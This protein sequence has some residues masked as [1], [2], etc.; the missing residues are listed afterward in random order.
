MATVLINDF[1]LCQEHILEVCDDCNFDLREEN[2]AFYG[3]DSIDRDA[4]EV[5]PVT[6]ADDGS[7][8]CDKH[9]SQC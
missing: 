7:Y 1:V 9:Q 6:L 3:Y 2:D 8:Q 4:V 5:P